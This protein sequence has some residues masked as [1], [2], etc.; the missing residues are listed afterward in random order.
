MNITALTQRDAQNSALSKYAQI[1]RLLTGNNLND[2][3]ARI[4]LV[5]TLENWTQRLQLPRLASTG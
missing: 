4:A 3:Q 2:D 1:G 5:E